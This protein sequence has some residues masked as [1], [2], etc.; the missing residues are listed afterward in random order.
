MSV[1]QA[2]GT[3]ECLGST[4]LCCL[5]GINGQQCNLF[6]SLFRWHSSASGPQ[7]KASRVFWRRDR[8]AG[9]NSPPRLSPNR[10]SSI[11]EVLIRPTDKYGTMY[12][13]QEKVSHRRQAEQYQSDPRK[14]SQSSRPVT[15]RAA[16]AS[17]ASSAHAKRGDIRNR[18][19]NTVPAAAEGIAAAETNRGAAC[20]PR[21][22]RR[23]CAGRSCSGS[24]MVSDWSVDSGISCAAR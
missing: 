13:Q 23:A 3:S 10:P 9:A 2:S 17:A 18:R 7:S 16:A 21:T 24:S 14:P 11:T 1:V 6:F 5:Y 4:D 12:E 15:N 8:P 20:A 19:A 22:R